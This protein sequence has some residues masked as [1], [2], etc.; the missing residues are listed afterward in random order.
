MVTSLSNP[1][2][3]YMYWLARWTTRWFDRYAPLH[4]KP[5]RLR[6]RLLGSDDDWWSAFWELG[7]AALLS[8]WG[9]EFKL[10]PEFEGKT[11]DVLVQ[12]AKGEFVVEVFAI[13]KSSSTN[14]TPT[15]TTTRR[16]RAPFN[17]RL[18]DGDGLTLESLRAQGRRMADRVGG[19]L[20]SYWDLGAPLVI[21]AGLCDDSVTHLHAMEAL[22]GPLVDPDASP[23]GVSERVGSTGELSSDPDH[24]R[25][26]SLVATISLQLC[27]ATKSGVFVQAYIHGNPS[28][29]LEQPELLASRPMHVSTL[30]LT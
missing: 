2:S 1:P 13:Q 27:G 26:Q 5:L 12:D 18:P 19:K 7:T 21:V 4:R 20:A 10:D 11:P 30:Q 25:L 23:P 8:E 22:R 3:D 28:C 14:G 9:A 6:E 16:P 29:R 15:R 17:R 24:E